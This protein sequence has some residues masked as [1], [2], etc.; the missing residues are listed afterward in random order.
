[1]GSALQQELIIVIIVITCKISS[2]KEV[3][4]GGGGG[5]GDGRRFSW[6]GAVAGHLVPPSPDSVLP[7]RPSIKP[8]V[9]GENYV[10]LK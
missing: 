8:D 4:S 3:P 5:R 2:L 1:V 10:T 7:G 9:Q 6:K